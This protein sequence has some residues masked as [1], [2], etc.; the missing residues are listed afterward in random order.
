MLNV[1]AEG[2]KSIEIIDATGRVVLN[3]KNAGSIDISNLSNG[4]YM[5]RTI[6]NEGVSMQKV[7]KK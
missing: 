6:T 5:V 2:V 1:V 4:I 7:I 3:T